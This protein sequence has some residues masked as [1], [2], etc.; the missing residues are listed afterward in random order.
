MTSPTTTHGAPSGG[1]KDGGA[2]AL[3]YARAAVTSAADMDDATVA[4]ACRTII[5]STDKSVDGA[6][7]FMAEVMLCLVEG[8][9]A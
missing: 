6:E 1:I 4:E 2:D 7:R 9:M 5:N 3:W 8:E